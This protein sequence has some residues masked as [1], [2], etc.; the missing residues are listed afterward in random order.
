[1]TASCDFDATL[2]AAKDGDERA[3]ASLFTELQPLLLRYLRAKDPKAAEDLAGDVWVG[4]VSGL[5]SFSGTER[6]FRGWVFTIAQ[7]RL[8]DHRRRTGR[9]PVEPVPDERLERASTDGSAHSIDQL[10]AQDAVN[11]LIAGL[12]AD[13][14]EVLLLRVVAD[15]DAAEVGRLMGRTPGSIRVLQHRA[16]RRLA[17]QLGS[18]DGRP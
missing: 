13:Q 10:T 1:M 14:A 16:L 2:S 17:E 15:L 12:P 6:D 9:R 7:R 8:V 11:R 5:H 3:M 4:V 18:Q